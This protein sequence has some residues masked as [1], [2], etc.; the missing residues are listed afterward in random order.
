M[1]I[2]NKKNLLIILL[3]GIILTGV[4][5]LKPKE[6]VKLG[7]VILKQEINNKTFAMYTETDNGYEEYEG[8]KFPSGYRLNTTK[9]KCIDNNGEEIENAIY[10]EN[11]Q[12]GVKS[13]KSFYCYLYFDEKENLSN[14]CNGSTMQDCLTTYKEQIT[15]IANL[16]ADQ[17][18]LYRYQG[19]RAIVDNNYI[20]FGTSDK[21]DCINDQDHYMYRI[22]GI[23]DD[24]RLKL[25]KNTLLKD[26]NITTFQWHNT[27]QVKTIWGDSDLFKRL[28]GK[29]DSL[30]NIFLN[31][32]EYPYLKEELWLNKIENSNWYQGFITGNIIS[33]YNVEQIY[34]ME[35]GKI[36]TQYYDLVGGEQKLVTERFTVLEDAKIGLM[37]MTDYNYA[38][39]KDGYN[40]NKMDNTCSQNWLH[41]FGKIKTQEFIIDSYGYVAKYNRFSIPLL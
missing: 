28:N 20:C 11:N 31:S 37:N 40:C 19:T 15:I 10:I 38:F 6:E 22:L 32:K 27:D 30:S 5:V 16:N 39:Q 8:N 35:N 14:I 3:I 34:Q 24:G 13:N 25:I 36:N 2:I 23:T 1:R 21:E 4:I 12:I 17:A 41:N 7:N 9:S 18:G 33:Q 29:H 26:G